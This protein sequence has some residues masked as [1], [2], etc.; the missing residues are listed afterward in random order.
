LIGAGKPSFVPYLYIFLPPLGCKSAW[1]DAKLLP[2]VLESGNNV[3]VRTW[4][5][6]AVHTK[7][8]S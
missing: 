6:G 2:F 3:S 1:L 5:G 4:N 7:A 8:R